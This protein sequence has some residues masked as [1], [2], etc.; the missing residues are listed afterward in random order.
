MVVGGVL[1]RLVGTVHAGVIG[2]QMG[3]AVGLVVG[4]RPSLGSALDEA[5]LHVRR[6]PHRLPLAVVHCLLL[7]H[8]ACYF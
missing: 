6:K 2:H 1:V 3:L 8:S 4:A 7:L 5:G